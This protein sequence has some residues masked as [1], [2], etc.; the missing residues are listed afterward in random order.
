VKQG[1]LSHISF[2][3]YSWIIYLFIIW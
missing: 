2:T 3:Y 1:D